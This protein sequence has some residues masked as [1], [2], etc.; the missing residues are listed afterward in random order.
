MLTF[1]GQP[2]FGHP[3]MP[4]PKGQPHGATSPMDQLSWGRALPEG[5]LPSGVTWRRA[6]P[7]PWGASLPARQLPPSTHTHT[8]TRRLRSARARKTRSLPG[9]PRTVPA[10]TYPA[11]EKRRGERRGAAG[12]GRE[13]SPLWG[14]EPAGQLRRTCEGPVDRGKALGSKW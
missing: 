3:K 8:Q 1:P 5:W 7:R 2:G 14:E 12:A 4:K 6:V 13:P 10:G 11:V 9:V